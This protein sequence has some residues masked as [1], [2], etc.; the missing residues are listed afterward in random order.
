MK[1]EYEDI[2]CGAYPTYE[3]WPDYEYRDKIGVVKLRNSFFPQRLMYSK[4]IILVSKDSRGR[5]IEIEKMI[6]KYKSDFKKI[7]MA[8]VRRF[9]KLGIEKI[10]ILKYSYIIISEIDGYSIEEMYSI[11]GF[12]KDDINKTNK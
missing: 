8:K 10:T 1:I 11:I 7:L 3:T 9:E 6:Y 5:L 4:R 12:G 2:P